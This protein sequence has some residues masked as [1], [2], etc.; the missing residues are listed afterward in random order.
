[1][2]FLPSKAAFRLPFDERVRILDT[3][4]I[5]W[6]VNKMGVRGYSDTWKPFEH[7][8][9]PIQKIPPLNSPGFY[10][11]HIMRVIFFIIMFLLLASNDFLIL[12]ASLS[13]RMQAVQTVYYLWLPK[14]T[15]PKKRVLIIIIN[16]RTFLC[17][18]VF[19]GQVLVPQG[20]KTYL[21]VQEWLFLSLI[22]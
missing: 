17:F 12:S 19:T 1:M 5:H 11:G 3:F 15:I 22:V 21:K 6:N 2:P 10:K 4:L 14:I 9:L 8:N 16:T 13:C 18:V 20:L 7:Y